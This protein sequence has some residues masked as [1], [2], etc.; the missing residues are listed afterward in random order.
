MAI[1]AERVVGACRVMSCRGPQ[2]RRLLVSEPIEAGEL[3]FAEA[4]LLVAAPL[5]LGQSALC[6]GCWRQDVTS[7]STFSMFDVPPSVR[8]ETGASPWRCQACRFGNVV[9]T[10][11]EA[12]GSARHG[13]TVPC[14]HGCGALFCQRECAAGYH[15]LLC[16]AVLRGTD[17][18]A[19][20]WARLHALL[21]A[22]RVCTR[23]YTPEAAVALEA[24]LLRFARLSR[25]VYAESEWVALRRGTQPFLDALRESVDAFCSALGQ[26]CP[27]DIDS[28][29]L[30]DS[31]CLCRAN[32]T[33]LRI[34][35]APDG[36]A[37][38]SLHAQ[39][40]HSCLPNAA[41]DCSL[42][43]RPLVQVVSV[44]PLAAGDEVT[45]AYADIDGPVEQR[46]EELQKRFGFLCS[47]QRC[48]KELETA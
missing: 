48:N 39:L 3:L 31:Y 13:P 34:D 17:L 4:P 46:R 27:V 14:P 2:G 1:G 47:C 33:A 44:R 24:D 11:C 30:F 19:S 7:R 21:V 25:T 43:E 26:P 16:S 12:C 42:V 18:W 8:V 9:G 6:E 32:A 41:V 23:L 40:N 38:L 35:G 10:E 45:I 15:K 28:E 22:I 36:S 37:V 5:V 29:A 20:R